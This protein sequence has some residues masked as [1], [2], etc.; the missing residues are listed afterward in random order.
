MKSRTLGGRGNVAGLILPEKA[1]AIFS[2]E[3]VSGIS[4]RTWDETED[5]E[6]APRET[7]GGGD[8]ECGVAADE[9]GLILTRDDE[10]VK[11]VGAEAIGDADLAAEI[12][13]QR[14]EM[15]ASFAVVTE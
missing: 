8:G 2:N 10:G 1:Q 9:D 13:L 15:Q 6:Q 7:E 11:L 14:G 5:G 3:I 4:E 12:G